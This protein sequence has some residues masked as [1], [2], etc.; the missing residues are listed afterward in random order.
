MHDGHAI[1]LSISVAI[2][3]QVLHLWVIRGTVSPREVGAW[4]LFLCHLGRGVYQESQFGLVSRLSSVDVPGQVLHAE[5]H[6]ESHV[7]GMRT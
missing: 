5:L 2:L 7:Q 6:V 1:H 4:V 3:A